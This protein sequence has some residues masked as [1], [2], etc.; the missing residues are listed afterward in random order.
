LLVLGNSLWI[1][2]LR[3]E[4]RVALTYEIRGS[5]ANADSHNLQ[6]PDGPMT[7]HIDVERVEKIA[8]H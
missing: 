6:T 7:I 8:R 3:D 1:A 2:L 5:L 4:V